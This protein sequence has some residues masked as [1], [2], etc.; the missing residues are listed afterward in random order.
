M[1]AEIYSLNLNIARFAP[2]SGSAWF[3]LPKF[4]QTKKAIVNVQI[5]DDGCFEYAIA[6]ALH[7]IQH[8][9]HSTRPENYI[10]YFKQDGLNDIEYLVNSVNIP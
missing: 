3:P 8:E 5:D 7:L 1:L 6:S 2:Y 10:Q 9:N 4:L